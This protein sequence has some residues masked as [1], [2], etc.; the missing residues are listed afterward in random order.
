MSDKRNLLALPSPAEMGRVDHLASA[1]VPVSVLMENAGRA[2]ARAVRR[3]TRPCRV[4]VLCGPGNNGGDG[5]V[6]ARYLAEAGWPVAAASLVAP[7][8]GTDAAAVAARFRGPCVQF[9]PDEVARADMVIDAVF[10]AGL[11]RDVAGPVSEVLAVAKRIVAVDMPSGIDGATGQIRGYAPRADLTVTFFRA[12]PGH[13]LLPGREYVGALEV[14]D[15]GIPEAVMDSV[16]VLTW[17]NEPGLWKL[18]V[19]GLEAYKYSRGVVSVAAGEAM[20][21]AARLAATAARRTGAGL[22]RIA[23]GKAAAVFRM[24]E[25]GLI[26]DENPLD[27]LL[28]DKRRKVWICGPGLLPEE[29]GEVLPKLLSSGRCVLADAG[30]FA[31]AADNPE[32]LHGVAVVTPHAG[33]FKRVFGAPGAD[34]LAAARAAAVRIGAVVVLKGATTIIAAPDGRA[35]LNV[36]ATSALGT[37]GSGD[38]L[39]GVI[40]ALLAAGMEHWSAAC[41][42][43]WLHGDA[44][45]RAGNWLIAEDLDTHLGEARETATRLQDGLRVP[46]GVPCR[47]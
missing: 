7:R 38:T 4:L 33:E 9:S 24:N 47:S 14:H 45:I 30:A 23:A 25:P 16:G 12:K 20:P 31:W 44:G 42:G 21:G 13:L 41:A 43:V 19:P 27:D 32:K 40:G 22:V 39:S 8:P 5:Y 15:I 11:S 3:F 2:V 46:S 35:A 36:H 18:P 17:Q 1:L 29:V 10:G 26:I 34:P 37:A 6:A 28:A